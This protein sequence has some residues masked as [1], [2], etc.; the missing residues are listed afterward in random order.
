MKSTK[1]APP[2]I[3]DLVCLGEKTGLILSAEIRDELA[4]ISTFNI[5][6]RYDDHKLSFYKKANK[7]FASKYINI[8]RG[9]LKWLNKYV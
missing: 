6:A 8:T 4:E 7:H 2:L 1:T 3:H 9:I 5:Q